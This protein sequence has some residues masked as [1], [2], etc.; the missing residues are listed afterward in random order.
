[1]IDLIKK[2][3]LLGLGSTML[4]KEKV[5][6]ALEALVEQGK[7]SRADAEEFASQIQQGADAQ[8]E[9]MKEEITASVR[10]NLEKFDICSCEDLKDLKK[11]VSALNARLAALE[12]KF[13]KKL[14]SF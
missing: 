9:E 6:E 5:D 4:V 3:L 7:L 8:W 1:M 14:S 11:E 2:T 13:E 12:L 10:E